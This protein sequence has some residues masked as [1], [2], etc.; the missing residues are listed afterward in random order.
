MKKREAALE[1]DGA[2][3]KVKKLAVEYVTRLL[4]VYRENGNTP[5]DGNAPED[6]DASKREESWERSS[7]WRETTPWR[8]WAS[9]IGGSLGG[10]GGGS[11]GECG[12]G[13]D[14]RQRSG[15]RR[16]RSPRQ[17]GKRA[18]RGDS[19]VAELG[20]RRRIAWW[21]L[22]AVEAK[23]RRRVQRRRRRRR[24]RKGRG[25]ERRWI[26]WRRSGGD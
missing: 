5:E 24:R 16:Q 6:G 21:R 7:R 9:R 8:S 4:L 23:I 19:V 13:E 14:R 11:G 1:K 26:R 22:S 2:E 20:V 18:G 10:G 25:M 12:G 15:G 17:R 3:V